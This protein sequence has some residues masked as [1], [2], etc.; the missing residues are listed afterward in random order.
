MPIISN[1]IIFLI[2]EIFFDGWISLFNR[3]SLFLFVSLF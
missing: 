3:P 2:D 1:L